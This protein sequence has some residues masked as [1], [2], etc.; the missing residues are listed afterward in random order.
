MK[1]AKLNLIFAMLIFGSIGIFVRKIGLPSAQVALARG[2]VGSFFL[3]L[4]L[5]VAQQKIGWR[6]VRRNLPFLIGSGSIFGFNWVF[7]FKSYQYTS[8]ANATLSYYCSPI[9]V[10]LLSPIVLKER[11]TLP[12]ML[13]VI[14]AMA[15]MFCIAR[16]GEKTGNGLF[17]GI[18]YGLAAAGLYAGVVLI[19]KFLK[20]L[21]ALESIFFQLAIATLAMLPYVLLS[22]NLQFNT[23]DASAWT[24]LAIVCVVHTGIAYILFFGSIQKL[25]GQTIAI[26]SYIDPMSAIVM[27][28]ILLNE[29]MEA[30][31]IIGG[32]LI[33][34]AAFVSERLGKKQKQQ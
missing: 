2:I 5:K 28:T 26:F 22:E 14:S 16:T 21:T 12:K 6:T 9:F 8:I 23:L 31:Q 34:G 17:L 4:A 13:C 29:K 32:I 15:G 20:D 30:L 10:M 27:S 19:N 1:N 7:L 24:L 18:A 33:I 3:L 25:Q 11:L